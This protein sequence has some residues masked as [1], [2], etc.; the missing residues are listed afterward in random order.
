MIPQQLR[1]LTAFASLGGFVMATP[2]SAASPPSAADPA[3]RFIKEMD[4]E[5]AD[6]RVPNWEQT[7]ALM[8]REAPKVGDVAPDFTLK[9]L[10]GKETIKLSQYAGNLPVVL[11]FGSYT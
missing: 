7:K 8:A 11:I 5:P 2:P 3:A 6:K 9:T 10:D 1:V 4:S